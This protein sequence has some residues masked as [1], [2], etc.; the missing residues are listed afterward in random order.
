MNEGHGLTLWDRCA[1]VEY[2]CTVPK[3]VK[4]RA[5]TVGRVH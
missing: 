4:K 1:I 2:A 3:L 5:E